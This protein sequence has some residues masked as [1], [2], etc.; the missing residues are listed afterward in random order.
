MRFLKLSRIR[1]RFLKLT[2]YL[3]SILSHTVNL[4]LENG[5]RMP[6]SKRL[7]TLC[8]FSGHLR[9]LRGADCAGGIAGAFGTRDAERKRGRR[10]DGS[11]GSRDYHGARSTA[12]H[13]RADYAVPHRTG[14]TSEGVGFSTP[15]NC[16]QLLRST[17]TF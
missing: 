10:R 2:T 8:C 3:T 17:K 7:A 4:N 9:R 12:H 16:T 11:G 14:P 1:Y 6:T 13:R 15:C 5:D